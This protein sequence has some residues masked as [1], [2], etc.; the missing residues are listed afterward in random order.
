MN[1]AVALGELLSTV[2]QEVETPAA[3]TAILNRALRAT[4][5][6]NG[7]LAVLNDEKGY[8]EIQHGEGP[9]WSLDRVGLQMEVAI[10]KRIGI[11]ALVAAT[12]ETFVT[13]NVN[14]VSAYQK[15]FESTISEI[16]VPIR[17]RHG[18]LRAVINLESDRENA[19]EDADVKI[20]EA[21]GHICA[22]VLE[23]DESLN[24]ERALLEVGSSI[25]RSMSEEELLHEVIEIAGEVL[26]L[27]ACSIF[28]LDSTAGNY[29]LRASTG[30]LKDRVGQLRY[31]AEEG[32]TGSVCS[33]GES[34]I[35]DH[36]SSNPK[37]RGK[38]TEFPTEEIASFIAVPIVIRGRS[39]GAVR[40]MRRRSENEFLD[41]RFT[42]D[43]LRV[44]EAIGDQLGVALD[45]IRA[46]Q[47]LIHAERMTAWGELSAKSAHMIGNR[48]FAL[49]GDINELS[50]LVNSDQPQISELRALRDSLDQNVTRLQELLQDFRD[51]VAAT[52]IQKEFGNLN[53][54]VV[55]TAREI[56]PKNTS[57]EL[58]F[59]LDLK[60]PEVPFDAVKM[61]Q[62]IGELIEN[63][64]N[65]FSEGNLTIRTRIAQPELAKRA[66]LSSSL[67]Y[68]AIEIADA[69]PGIEL[70]K[71]Q[72][73]FQPFY[74]GR[75]KGMG[76]G[77]SIVKGI[78][79]AH[80]GTVL[81][82][83]EE[84]HGANFVILLPLPER[85]ISREP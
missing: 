63:S 57:V 80:G 70:A 61:R 38:Y 46:V 52:Q 49:K 31:E 59:E 37:W 44:L 12:G 81:E 60:L 79:D 47:K 71:K 15:L 45:S 74:S 11:T 34:I 56:F 84:G 23:R 3:L 36:P 20:A 22:L 17:D 29:V 19:Y 78:A 24:R 13:G 32:V 73:V 50:H 16:A 48:V 66:K 7:I 39:I 2:V 1:S 54:L 40:V 9:D 4:G 85:P 82:I 62:A 8:L 83:G 18:L 33:S 51:F 43:D 35:L 25:D 28:L 68:A 67:R 64:L 10:G 55:E 21:M 72:L 53:E 5:S 6:R 75:V 76:L 27:Q 69:G 77:L 30:A 26:R 42:E 58:R 14:E 41:N 65:F